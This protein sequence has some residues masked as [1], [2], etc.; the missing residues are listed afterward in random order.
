MTIEAQIEELRAELGAISN[1]VEEAQIRA[2]LAMAL[3]E[4]A[5]LEAAFGTGN[6]ALE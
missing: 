2:E 3:T 6:A 4:K 5:R 1:P